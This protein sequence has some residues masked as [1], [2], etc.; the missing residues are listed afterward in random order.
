[1]GK[2]VDMQMVVLKVGIGL[3][4]EWTN[5]SLTGF[6]VPENVSDIYVTAFYEFCF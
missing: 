2:C 3:G 5:D 4:D 6:M 1:M